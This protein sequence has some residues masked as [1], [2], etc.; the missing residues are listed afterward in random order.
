MLSRHRKAVDLY[1]LNILRMYRSNRLF[2]NCFGI[3][4]VQR[5]GRQRDNDR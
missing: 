2:D 5:H 3:L 1:R 4:G